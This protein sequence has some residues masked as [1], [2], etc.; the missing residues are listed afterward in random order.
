MLYDNFGKALFISS[1]LFTSKAGQPYEDGTPCY[2]GGIE[3]K[4]NVATFT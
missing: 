4:A 3:G 1:S 2:A